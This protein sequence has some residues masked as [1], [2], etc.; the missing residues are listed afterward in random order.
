MVGP[1][2]ETLLCEEFR[3]RRQGGFTAPASAANRAFKP[4]YRTRPEKPCLPLLVRNDARP[5]KALRFISTYSGF[6]G[7]AASQDRGASLTY[8]SLKSIIARTWRA[9]T[10]SSDGPSRTTASSKS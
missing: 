10:H 8:L 3:T 9:P 6:C 4:L 7:Q 1:S 5:D 2:R